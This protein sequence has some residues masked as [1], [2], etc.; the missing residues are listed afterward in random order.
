MG[1]PTSLPEP[2]G[3]AG[4]GG[5]NDS[6]LESSI[7]AAHR[8]ARATSRR[9]HRDIRPAPAARTGKLRQE[10]GEAAPGPEHGLG[11]SSSQ[12]LTRVV[13]FSRDAVVTCFVWDGVS[14]DTAKPAEITCLS[15]IKAT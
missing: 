1:A 3:R 2:R 5:G 9:L 10:G 11:S 12:R 15:V 4:T 14:R 13:F 6:R 7:A 8:A